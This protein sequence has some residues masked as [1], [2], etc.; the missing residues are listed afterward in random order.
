MSLYSQAEIRD[1]VTRG[2]ITWAGPALML[3]ARSILAIA[4]QALV[5]AIF[6][7]GQPDA[8]D[9]A[10]RWWTV[11]G[12]V[13]DLVCIGLLIWLTRQEGIR[14][15][16]LGA[17]FR[18]RWGRD[19]LIG[20]G[21][22]VVIFPTLLFAPLT[23][24]T[25]AL[26]IEPPMDVLPLAGALYS[27]LVWPIIWAYAEDN[28]YLGYA[29]P[30]ITALTGRTW[31]AVAVVTLFA[32]LQHVFLPLRL[33]WRY[34]LSRFLSFVPFIIVYCLIYLRQRRLLPI[35]ILHW[36]ANMIGPLLALLMSMAPEG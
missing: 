2:R 7:S 13:I 14:L 23:L 15:L 35:H 36:A 26:G 34:L 20:L 19:I 22:F 27:I 18:E 10:G 16:D 30:R 21:L 3:V 24:L 1:R 11:Y 32:T 12:T 33:E 31:V 28:T 29:L 5:S 17:Y 4:C 8:W 6:F 9:Q 25:S